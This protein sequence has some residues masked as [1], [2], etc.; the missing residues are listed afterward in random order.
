MAYLRLCRFPTVF[1]ALADI[2]AGFLLSHPSLEPASEFVLLLLA[3]GTLYLSGMV[4][5]DV[6]DV[7]QDRE[8]RPSRPIPSGQVPLRSA[9][10]FG[11]VLMAAGLGC[12]ALADFKSLSVALLIAFMIL[13]YDGP[14][15]RTPLGPIG[16]GCC[17]FLNILLGASSSGVRF[18][19]VW[20]MPQIWMAA[21]LG[22]Y[23]VGVTWFARTEA[24][25]SNRVHLLGGLTFV[26]CGLTMLLLWFSGIATTLGLWIGPGGVSDSLGILFLWA[27]VLLTINRRSFSAVFRPAPERVQP[28]VGTMLLSIIVID[29]MAVYFK[30]GD[31]GLP[32]VFM[33][34]ALLIPAV[35][36]RKWIPLS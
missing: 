14:L 23:I 34:L 5:N 4:F 25:A 17:R 11:G 3:S 12:A 22:I 35:G 33:M 6:F 29:A 1:T 27:I 10:V 8:E 16:M 26:N 21:S 32:F 7:A 36:L 28:A 15:K 19:A 30:L 20:Q 31:P 18:S 13:L 9:V 2:F 24:R